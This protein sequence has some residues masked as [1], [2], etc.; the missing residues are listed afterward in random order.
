[1][2]KIIYSAFAL[3]LVFLLTS[4]VLGIIG[5]INLDR[6]WYLERTTD[7]TGHDM[8]GYIATGHQLVKV[9][10]IIASVGVLSLILAVCVLKI[11]KKKENT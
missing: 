10:L 7:H 1:M 2:K 5:W 9:C 11:N 4:I 6:G 8:Y 3:S